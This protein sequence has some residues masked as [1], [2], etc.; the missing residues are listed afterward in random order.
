MKIIN[1][2]ELAKKIK[3]EAKEKIKNKKLNLA[4][5]LVG[6]NPVSRL[7]VNLKE[8]ACREVGIDFEKIEFEENENEEKI[9][10]KIN[11]LNKKADG[12]IIQLPLPRHLNKEILLN[13]IGY[14]KDI[15]GLTSLS[16]ER[17]KSGDETNASCTAKAVIYV[18]EKNKINFDGKNVVLIGYGNVGKPISI[19]LRNRKVNLDICDE[20]TKDL[21]SHTLNADLLISCAGVPNLIKKDMV[22]DGVIAID[23]GINKKDNKIIG[24]I[25]ESVKEKA[26]LI[27]PVPG[28]I[29][30]LTIAMLI[31]KIADK[32]I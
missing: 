6:N 17:L 20:F 14:D 8:K 28:G 16:F 25:E 27:C 23:V 24:D 1:G 18:L 19:M 5:I 22:K 29:G 31:K 15:D 2:I 3:E 7:Y 30:P 4:V 32:I 12:I 26:S 21:K 10:Y 9:I 13:E 11:E